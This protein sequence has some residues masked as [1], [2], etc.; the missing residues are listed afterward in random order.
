MEQVLVTCWSR[1][2]FPFTP[3]LHRYFI[4]D[5]EVVMTIL[6][7]PHSYGYESMVQK[8]FFLTED[9]NKNRVRLGG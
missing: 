7:Y 4:D 8:S 2:R 6:I 1:Y 5:K 3:F 9:V